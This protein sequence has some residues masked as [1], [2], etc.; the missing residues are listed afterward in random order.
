M[1]SAV[2][3][4]RL[5]SS[6]LEGR[7][8]DYPRNRTASGAQ[9]RYY[10]LGDLK[11]GVDVLDVIAVFQG[12]EEFEE[13]GRGLFVNRRGGFWTPYQPSRLSLAEAL[14]ECVAHLVE[15]IEGR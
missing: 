13:A 3:L 4:R 11:I 7:A 2:I 6:R 15:I 1:M 5:R 8:I 9:P 10:V 14:L 12:L